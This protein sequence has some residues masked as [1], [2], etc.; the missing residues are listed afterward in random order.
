[1]RATYH[2]KQEWLAEFKRSVE[3]AWRTDHVIRCVRPG[4]DLQVRPRLHIEAVED[5]SHF[6]VTVHKS[7]ERGSDFRPEVWGRSRTARFE[8]DHTKQQDFGAGIIEEE[9]RRVEAMTEPPITFDLRGDAPVL[10]AAE[11]RRVEAMAADTRSLPPSSPRMRVNVDGWGTNDSDNVAY[12]A[13]EQIAEMMPE[14]HTWQARSGQN[15]VGQVTF[16][17]PE[18]PDHM[19]SDSRFQFASHEVGHMLGLTEEYEESNSATEEQIA[20][21]DALIEASGADSLRRGA[22]T[23]SMMSK[24]SDVLTGHLVTMWEAL[25]IMT[26]HTLDAKEWQL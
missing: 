22:D 13:A 9:K 3:A 21:Q 14:P 16:D 7:A 4:W 26:A 17:P 19:R 23:S 10:P 18:H 25:G 15:A 12:D 2:Q 1:M 5:D 24:G 11:R 20:A 8:E 6:A